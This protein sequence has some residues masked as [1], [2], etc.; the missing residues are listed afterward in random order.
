MLSCRTPD[1][2]DKYLLTLDS[3][4]KQTD[5]TDSIFRT[6]PFEKAEE[7]AKTIVRKIDAI[8]AIDKGKHPEDMVNLISTYSIIRWF[9][10]ASGEEEEREKNGLKNVKESEQEPVEMLEKQ[11]EYSRSQLKNLRQIGRAH[12]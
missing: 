11:I 12:V 3:L 1:K 4:E 7:V 5:M 10:I 8:N 9:E 2:T 6:I